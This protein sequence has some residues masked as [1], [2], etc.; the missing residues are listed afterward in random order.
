MLS[1]CLYISFV[2][3]PTERMFSTPGNQVSVHPQR[4]MLLQ[5]DQPPGETDGNSTFHTDGN[6]GCID[7]GSHGFSADDKRLHGAPS[8]L[9]V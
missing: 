4:M 2:C 3:R 7:H 9:V 6:S 8:L 5:I 1:C